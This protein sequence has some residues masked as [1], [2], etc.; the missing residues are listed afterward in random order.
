MGLG[1]KNRVGVGLGG[2]TRVVGGDTWGEGG[3]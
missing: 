3:D 2:K 1:G